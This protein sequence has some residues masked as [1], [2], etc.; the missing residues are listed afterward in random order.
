MN[1]QITY[2]APNLVWSLF[3]ATSSRYPTHVRFCLVGLRLLLLEQ[4]GGQPRDDYS[5][6]APLN[7][8]AKMKYVDPDELSGIHSSPT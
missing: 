4:K 7:S 1:N 8:H 5:C 6:L 2:Q 3:H